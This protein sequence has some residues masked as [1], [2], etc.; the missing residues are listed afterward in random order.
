MLR[1]LASSV[2]HLI[3]EA[4]YRHRESLSDPP[5]DGLRKAEPCCRST[6]TVWPKGRCR[7]GTCYFTDHSRELTTSVRTEKQ[8]PYSR[9]GATERG[10]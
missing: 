4:M 9:S 3:L 7:A 8:I 2:T 6:E 5:G 10:D 1:G